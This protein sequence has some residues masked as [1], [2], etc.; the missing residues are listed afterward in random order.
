MDSRRICI[1]DTRSFNC[2]STK[3]H[4]KLRFTLSV[5]SLTT[6]VAVLL[7]L[8]SFVLCVDF[9]KEEE[10][11]IFLSDTFPHRMV[12]AYI[13]CSFRHSAKS[14]ESQSDSILWFP[15]MPIIPSHFP[16]MNCISKFKKHCS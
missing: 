8:S 2:R 4:H 14:S 7:F 6:Q 1:A 9:V 16:S 5:S 11:Q 3:K 10:H 15:V 12:L 13:I